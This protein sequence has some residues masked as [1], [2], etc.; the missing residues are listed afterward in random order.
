MSQVTSA[1]DK[2]LHIDAADKQSAVEKVA[3]VQKWLADQ[4][5]R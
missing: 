1:D 5:A 2:Y 3:T 4:I